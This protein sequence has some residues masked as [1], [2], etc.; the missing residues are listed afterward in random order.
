MNYL[1]KGNYGTGI[2]SDYILDE[3]V[4]LLAENKLKKEWIK[5]QRII[6]NGFSTTFHDKFNEKYFLN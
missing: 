3:T 5:N 6:N 2:I 4:T 1:R